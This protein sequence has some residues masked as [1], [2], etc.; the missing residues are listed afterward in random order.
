[1]PH[2]RRP[3]VWLRIRFGCAAGVLVLV[4]VGVELAGW[5]TWPVVVVQIVLIAGIVATSVLDLRG[6][7]HRRAGGPRPPE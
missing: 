6:L 4:L 7:R 3:S 5:R 1:M 2:R